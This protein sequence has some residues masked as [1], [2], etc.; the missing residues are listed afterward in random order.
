VPSARPRQTL[1]KPRQSITVDGRKNVRMLGDLIAER[2]IGSDG[3]YPIT[4]IFKRFSPSLILFSASG[5]VM[6]RAIGEDADARNRAALIVEIRLN[7]DVG[8]RCVL[9]EIWKTELSLVQVVEE[10][11]FE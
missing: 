7:E 1:E 11:A 4:P 10:G 9:G 3:Q 8:D 6:V 2:P 5:G